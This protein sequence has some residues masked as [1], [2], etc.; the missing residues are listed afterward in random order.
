MTEKI[1]SAAIFMGGIVSLP[2]PARHHTIMQTM[3]IVM[4]LSHLVQPYDQ[5]FLSSDGR[6]L[7]RVEAYY[8]AL[9][10]KQI[11][12]KSVPELFSEDLW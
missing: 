7:N 2:P 10:A 5:G 9:K 12:P 11:E 6:Y 8:L 3:D 4:H 1:V